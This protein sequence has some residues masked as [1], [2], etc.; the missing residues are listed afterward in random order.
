MR[1]IVGLA[2]CIG[3]TALADQ[4]ART[5]RDAFLRAEF[6]EDLQRDIAMAKEAEFRPR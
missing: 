4:E 5:D 2:L 1:R 6:R 3:A